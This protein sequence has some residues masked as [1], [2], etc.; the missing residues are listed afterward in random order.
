MD[1]LLDP[2]GHCRAAAEPPIM[3]Q[4]VTYCGS[5]DAS[6]LTMKNV[7]YHHEVKQQ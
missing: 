7:P 3:P 5:S 1:R 2:R 6:S 4:G